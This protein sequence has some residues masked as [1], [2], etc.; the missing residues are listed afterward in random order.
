MNA[1]RCRLVL[2]GLL[3]LLAPP[4]RLGA[5]DP[6]SRQP[7]ART[8]QID[9]LSREALVYAPAAA[10]PA[11]GH[12]LVFGF[13]GH[14]G[15]SRSAA[16]QYRL[17]ELWPEAIVIYP[18]GVPTPGRLTDPEGKRSGWQASSGDQGD[19]DLK[20]FDAL[21]NTARETWAVDPR[22]VYATGHSNGG[23]FTYLLWAE[24]PTLLAAVAPSA[25]AAPRSLPKLTPKP[26]LHLAGRN[27]PLVKFTWQQ[28]TLEAVKR[29]NGC[30]GTGRDWS[31][32]ATLFPSPGG[33]PLVIYLH[34]GGHRY[35]PAGPELIVRFF[36][37]H[38]RPE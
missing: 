7:A 10:K 27:D 2:A 11:G 24:R 22:R 3:T 19:R 18:Q 23:G 36:Q 12:P 6:G 15:Q 25:S 32:N 14:G 8:W 26:A 37:A 16:R 30:T 28:H 20:F 1:L 38:P 13:H 21:V 29:V 33:T 17:H 4:F 31:G 9:G 5:E 35:P 34:D